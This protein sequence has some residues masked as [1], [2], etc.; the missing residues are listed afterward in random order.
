MCIRDRSIYD[1]VGRPVYGKTFHDTSVI[2]ETLS[3][4]GLAAGVYEVFV[5][6]EDGTINTGR[7]LKA[8]R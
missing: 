4:Q 2:S 6:Q 3:L 1:A 5:H 8:V 7:F